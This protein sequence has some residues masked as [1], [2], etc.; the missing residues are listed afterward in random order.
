MLRH[1]T[2]IRQN[3]NARS[4]PRPHP[5]ERTSPCSHAST[6]TDDVH[7]TNPP[8]FTNSLLTAASHV[9]LRG[10]RVELGGCTDVSQSWWEVWECSEER[11][12]PVSIGTIWRLF[13]FLVNA[14]ARENVT[15]PTCLRRKR[16]PRVGVEADS[17]LYSLAGAI[18]V[19]GGIDL[20]LCTIGRACR[21]K[22]AVDTQTTAQG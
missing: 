9:R 2:K 16:A 15:V 19:Q 5:L 13:F 6:T 22:F 10:R 20:L 3:L 1:T 14:A 7:K 12:C 18:A 17:C 8:D 4:R 11:V 21:C